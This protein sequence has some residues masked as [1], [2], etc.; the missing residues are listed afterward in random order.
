ME[1][2]K[3]GER[4]EEKRRRSRIL[5]VLSKQSCLEKKDPKNNLRIRLS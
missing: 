3:E 2:E 4:D 1:K 5:L